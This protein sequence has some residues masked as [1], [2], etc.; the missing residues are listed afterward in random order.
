MN[1]LYALIVVLVCSF[2]FVLSYYLN[3]KVKVDGNE[4]N[5]CEGCT[6]EAC[7]NKINKED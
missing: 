1:Y 4:T 7:Y 2:I 6:I 5:M 3:S